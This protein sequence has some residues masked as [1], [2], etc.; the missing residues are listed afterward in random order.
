MCTIFHNVNLF[1]DSFI[2]VQ[3]SSCEIQFFQARIFNS[4]ENFIHILRFLSQII[5]PALSTFIFSLYLFL[6]VFVSVSLLLMYPLSSQSLCV[7]PFVCTTFDSIG[8][9]K[10]LMVNITSFIYMF[11]SSTSVLETFHVFI[12]SLAFCNIS[13]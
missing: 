10:H 12:C 5:L 3:L 7:L 1:L 13:K 6:S 11:I 9:S 8:N 2:L 4:V